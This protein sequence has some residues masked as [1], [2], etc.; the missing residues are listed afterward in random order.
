MSRLGAV[1]LSGNGF[2]GRMPPS[3]QSLTLLQSLY[4]LLAKPLQNPDTIYTSIFDHVSVKVYIPRPTA[5]QVAR[6]GPEH[7]RVPFEY[8]DVL[9]SGMLRLIEGFA[10]YSYPEVSCTKTLWCMRLK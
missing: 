1:Y 8:E 5:A 10:Y 3:W 6:G 4:V 7:V 9:K 2:T